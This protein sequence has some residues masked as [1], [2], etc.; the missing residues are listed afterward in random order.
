MPDILATIAFAMAPVL[1]ITFTA[2]Y[3]FIRSQ[4]PDDE[5]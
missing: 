1:A 2:W 5:S 4:K 3:L